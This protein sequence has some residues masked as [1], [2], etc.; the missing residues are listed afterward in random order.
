MNKKVL[1]RYSIYAFISLFIYKYLKYSK[2]A[3]KLVSILLKND[4]KYLTS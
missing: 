2:A 1:G 4:I 3:Y